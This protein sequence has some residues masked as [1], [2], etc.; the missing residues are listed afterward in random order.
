MR[1]IFPDYAVQQRLQEIDQP[2]RVHRALLHPETRR[3][4]AVA[5]HAVDLARREAAELLREFVA[6]AREHD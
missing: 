4:R 2:P 6:A 1:K 5:A 3:D